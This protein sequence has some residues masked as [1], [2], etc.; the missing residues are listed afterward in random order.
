MLPSGCIRCELLL[1]SR[2]ERCFNDAADL[3]L[4][5]LA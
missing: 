2:R 1:E 5:F 4:N 3:G